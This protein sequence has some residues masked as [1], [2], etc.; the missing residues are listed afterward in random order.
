MKYGQVI[1]DLNPNGEIPL[2]VRLYANGIIAV[3]NLQD[4]CNF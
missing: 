1:A 4:C 3:S 2:T